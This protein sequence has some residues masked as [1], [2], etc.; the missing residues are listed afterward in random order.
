MR[1]TAGRFRFGLHLTV[2]AGAAPAGQAAPGRTGL[3]A[4]A[5]EVAAAGD[6]GTGILLHTR[7]GTQ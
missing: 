2:H 5:A 7:K 1:R 4:K 6:C 3:L